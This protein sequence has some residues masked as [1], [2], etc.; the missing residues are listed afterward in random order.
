MEMKIEPKTL[1]EAGYHED[2]KSC[3]SC[4]YCEEHWDYGARYWVC[5]KFGGEY[6]SCEG[7]C[8]CYKKLV[9]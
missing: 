6:I 5:G 8:S 4:F 3:G 1:E 9:R 7:L 2:V